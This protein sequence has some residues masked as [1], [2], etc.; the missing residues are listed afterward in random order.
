[1]MT[2]Q[3]KGEIALLILKERVFEEGAEVSSKTKRGVISRAKKLGLDPAEAMEFAEM[4]VR[5]T[6]DRVFPKAS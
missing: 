6:V 1:M 4:L 3:R 2:E 5:D